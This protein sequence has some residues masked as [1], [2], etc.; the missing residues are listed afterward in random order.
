MPFSIFPHEG[1][2]PSVAELTAVLGRS[3]ALWHAGLQRLADSLGADEM[4][5][6]SYG[7]VS[8]WSLNVKDRAGTLAYLYP[9][10]DGFIVVVNIGHL[11]AARARAVGP[12]PAEVEAAIATGRPYPKGQM[13]ATDVCTPRDL[14]TVLALCRVIRAE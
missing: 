5:W 10:Q 11:A 2:C 4:T 7:R 12:L 8:G 9:Q 3:G 1:A 14:D 6:Q 13:V